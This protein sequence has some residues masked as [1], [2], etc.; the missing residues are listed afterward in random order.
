MFTDGSV[1]LSA[2]DR[3][4]PDISLRKTAGGSTRLTDDDYLEGAPELVVEIAASS[5]SYDLHTKKESY[6]RAG[7]REYIV[8]RTT[9]DAIDWFVLDDTGNFQPL[10]PGSDGVTRSRMFPGLAVDTS[11]LAAGDFKAIMLSAGAPD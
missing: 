9:E 8:W 1:I 7:G 10:L 6:R 5:A 4:Q 2:E 11:R 3:V